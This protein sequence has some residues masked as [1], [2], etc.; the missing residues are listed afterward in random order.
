MKVISVIGLL[1]FSLGIPVAC[2]KQADSKP[3]LKSTIESYYQAHPACLWMSD[4]K[5]PA[6]VTAEDAKNDGYDALVDQGVMTRTTTAKEKRVAASRRESTYTISPQGQLFWTA[7]AK[8]P[9]YGNLCYGRRQVTS[10]DNVAPTPS[11]PGSVTMVSYHYT[12]TGVPEWASSA[13]VQAA[14]PKLD[15]V[16][17][18]RMSVATLTDTSNGW[19]MNP[20]AAGMPN[21]PTSAAN[22]PAPSSAGKHKPA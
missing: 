17:S 2:S 4:H 11:G 14:F 7:D 5:F 16:T 19:K 21:E 22:Q 8:D 1:V 13:E 3:M 12:V 18:A 15:G 9:G 6:Q 20:P 10:I